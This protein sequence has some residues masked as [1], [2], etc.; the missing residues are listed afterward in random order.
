MFHLT[1]AIYEQLTLQPVYSVL[2]LGLDNAG[3]TTLLETLKDQYLPNYNRIPAS[4]IVPTVGQNLATLKINNKISLKFWDVGGQDALR[5]L[6]EEYYDQANAIIFVIDSCDPERLNECKESLKQVINNDKFKN[7][8]IPVLML[9]NKQDLNS[10]PHKMDIA[11]I[12]EVFNKMAA[13]LDAIDSTV[14]PVSA[15]TGEGV[16]EAIEWVSARVE[17]NKNQR[18]PQFKKRS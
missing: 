3:K 14:L 13:Q 2:I 1:Q 4:R 17:L 5:E 6:W 12:K 18:P 15:Q 8:G 11:E 7:I 9:A 10:L 16:R